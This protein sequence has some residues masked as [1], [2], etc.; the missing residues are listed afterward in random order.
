METGS[1]DV[2]LKLVVAETEED[3]DESSV[4]VDL[5]VPVVGTEV[6]G[7]LEVEVL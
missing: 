4:L 7:P 3:F 2:E 5:M 6:V 1:G